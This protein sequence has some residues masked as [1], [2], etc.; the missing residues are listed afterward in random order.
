MERWLLAAGA[1]PDVL[2]VVPAMGSARS[3]DETGGGGGEARAA[4]KGP[5]GTGSTAGAVA[6][7]AVSVNARFRDARTG[8][9]AVN[10]TMASSGTE[11]GSVRRSLGAF[12]SGVGD[13][14]EAGASRGTSVR[15]SFDTRTGWSG[16]RCGSSFRLYVLFRVAI[17]RMEHWTLNWR[18]GNRLQ[19]EESFSRATWKLAPSAI[20]QD[21]R[22]F[23]GG[24]G[25]DGEIS[26]RGEILRLRD[27]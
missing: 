22:V 10:P 21:S 8:G 12:G 18:C 4:R 3:V 16:R 24:D 7:E 1:A 6:A 19:R 14:G 9:T 2:A 11:S 5:R 20:V 15:E 23:F 13:G 26:P 17:T 27:L 25:E